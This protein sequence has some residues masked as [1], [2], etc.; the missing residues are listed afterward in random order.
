M[1]DVLARELS[2][3][4][5]TSRFPTS[6]SLAELTSAF[7]VCVER[8]IQSLE[9]GGASVAIRATYRP[10]ERAY[11]MHWSYRVGREA[12][13][14][15]G[16]PSMEGVDIEWAHKAAD[17][18]VD[19]AASRAAAQAMVSAFDIVYRPA[20]ASR[21]T[22]RRAIDMTITNYLRKTFIDGRNRSCL[23]ERD[24]DL[25]EVGRS[26]GVIKL[27]SDRPHWSDDGR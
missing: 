24:T 27:L 16:I 3:A 2:G 12:F 9:A 6:N 17:G 21:H 25:F 11:L 26:F 14:P 4:H 5:W 1:A 7:R 22:E 23:V 8:F 13:S 10:K 19:L 20:L 15:A 18:L